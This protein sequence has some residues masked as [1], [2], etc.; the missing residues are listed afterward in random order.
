MSMPCMTDPF[1]ECF[2]DC[3]NCMR[4]IAASRFDDD[5]NA[6]FNDDREDEEEWV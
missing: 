1:E 2:S 4:A 6:D 5:Y 3:P